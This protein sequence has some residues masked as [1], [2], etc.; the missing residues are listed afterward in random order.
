METLVVEVVCVGND[1]IVGAVRIDV[2][3]VGS[4]V[5]EVVLCGG[6]K[7]E[8]KKSKSGNDVVDVIFGDVIIGIDVIIFCFTSAEFCR[9]SG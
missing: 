3:S 5:N 7:I 6:P 8:S 9:T 1:G 4:C 2:G